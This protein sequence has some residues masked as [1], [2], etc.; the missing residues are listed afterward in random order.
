MRIL[1]SGSSRVPLILLILLL[2]GLLLPG[3]DSRTDDEARINPFLLVAVDGAEWSAIDRLQA[4]GS[5]PTF[6]RL[7]EAGVETSLATDYGHSPVIW[8]TV[9]TGVGPEKHGITGFVLPTPAGDSPVSSDMRKVPAIW[10]MLSRARMR[11]AALGWWGSWPA[12]RVHGV[13]VTDRLSHEKRG[14]VFPAERSE[15]LETVM[16]RSLD[17]PRVFPDYATERTILRHDEMIASMATD[18]TPRGFDLFMVYLHSPDAVGHHKWKYFEPQHPVYEEVDAAELAR[19]RDHV[20]RVYR[21]VDTVLQQL[22]DAAPD[23]T[24]IVVISDHGFRAVKERVRVRMDFDLLLERLGFLVRN[25]DGEIDFSRTR[26]YT[27]ATPPFRVGKSL[28]YPTL[29]REPGGAVTDEARSGIRRELAAALDDVRYGSGAPVFEVRDPNER[30]S[31]LGADLIAQVL[32]EGVTDQM[33]VGGEPMNGVIRKILHINGHHR[34]HDAGIFIAA[35]PD[36]D[37][38]AELD[39]L[40]IF[41]ITPT[42]LFG[43]GL[44]VAEDFDGRAW[45]ELFTDSFRANHPWKTVASWGTRQAP[46]STASEGDE[47]IVQELRALGYL[48]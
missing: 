4:E 45:T 3:C 29:G 35:G 16:E 13:M 40:S 15:W 42:L 36:I 33:Y 28:R 26:L 11:V 32:L 30:E 34:P 46:S 25:D 37:S 8:T 9:A 23:N 10:N 48:D 18:L 24:N 41:D 47:A 5:L 7:R 31:Q 43:L 14:R 38:G 27:F 44:P 12:E 22:W 17:G 2:G 1:R 39:G 21:A 6:Q 19:Y 20:P